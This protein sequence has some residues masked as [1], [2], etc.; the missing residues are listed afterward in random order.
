[1][2]NL[3]VI[4]SLFLAFFTSAQQPFEKGRIIDS[5]PISIA[6]NE[7]FAMYVPEKFNPDVLSSIVFI[8]EPAGRGAIG[9]QPFIAASEAY[10]HILVCSN[11]IKNG[12]YDVNFDKTD[13]WFNQVF[14]AFTIG[15]NQVYLAGFSGGARLATTIAV[16]TKKITGVIACGA[17]FS[18]NQAHMPT[19]QKFSFVGVC[20]NEDMNFTEMFR[21]KEYLD[22]TGFTNTLITFDGGHSWPPAAELTKAF[23]WLAIKAHE[24]E[25]DTKTDTDLLKSY[26]KSYRH[27]LNTQQPLL[28]SERLNRTISSYRPFFETD[29]LLS[30]LDSLQKTKLY[31]T[32]LQARNAAFGKESKLTETFLKRFNMEYMDPKNADFKWWKREL[33]KLSKKESGENTEMSHLVA[34]I[35]FKVFAAAYERTKFAVPKAT[36]QQKQYCKSLRAIIYPPKNQ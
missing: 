12:S 30:K 27:A 7:T 14:G 20:G 18:Q 1:M 34:R 31:K 11:T 36:A 33:Q 2:K 29:S 13:R 4:L 15:E 8:F 23:D 35:K 26:N 17:S 21:A 3:A 16:L 22:K 9:I 28:M 6:L 25:Y 19:N 5:I 10:G 32:A 24:K